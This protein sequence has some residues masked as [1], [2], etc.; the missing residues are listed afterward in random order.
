MK[1]CQ[2]PSDNMPLDAHDK[3]T[4]VEA[5]TLKERLSVLYTVLKFENNS[6]GESEWVQ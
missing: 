1:A 3:Q 4:L 5:G 2:Q 6:H